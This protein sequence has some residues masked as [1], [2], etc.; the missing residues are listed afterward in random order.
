MQVFLFTLC[1]FLIVGVGLFFIL[2]IN[3]KIYKI[4]KH[5]EKINKLEE[6][7]YLELRIVQ[8]KTKDICK[9]I[10]KITKQKK[11]IL[12]ELLQDIFI[13]ILPFKKI[14]SL[15]LLYSVLKKIL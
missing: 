10:N 14:K 8:Y 12:T 7:I 2:Y 6:K 5:T 15:L 1:Y 13:A 4:R 11:T 9:T 3:S